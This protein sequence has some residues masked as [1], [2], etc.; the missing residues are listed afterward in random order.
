MARA[1]TSA[2][3]RKGGGAK[4]AAKAAT[5]AAKAATKAAKAATRPAKAATRPAKA[6][7]KVAKAATKPAAAVRKPAVRKPAAKKTARAEQR[8]KK[9]TAR[10]ALRASAS[11]ARTA[12]TTARK[13]T[14][15][16]KPLRG[17]T[18]TRRRPAAGRKNTA[19]GDPSL[20]EPL[21]AGERAD[22]LRAL[23]E[24][25]RIAPMA[26][27]G[28]YRVIS[29]EPHA[30]KP[31]APMAGRRLARVVI[32]DYSG[33]RCVEASVDLDGG[34][35][36]HL[37]TS[38]AQ[39]ML[40]R[41]EEAA[42]VAIAQADDR[43]KAELSL[44]DEPLLAM[45]YWSDRDSDLAFTRRSAAVL[46]GRPGNRPSLVAVVDLLDGQVTEVTPAASW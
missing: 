5:K 32:Y 2:P 15:A 19:P 21:T 6:A 28:R 16:A 30:A 45:H 22:A 34:T 39:P 42:A 41:E 1:K 7:T 43:V 3:A 46:F 20:F 26:K 12:R 35:V 27:V 38:G 29:V 37:R 36:T 40:C 9:K 4:K 24:D 18:I 13:A 8:A 23:T 31:P 17:S 33:D 44:S 10:A 14:R 11:R 25:K